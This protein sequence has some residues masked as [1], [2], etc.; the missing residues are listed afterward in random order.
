MTSTVFWL[1]LYK[2]M[3]FKVRVYIHNY[4]YP[5]VVPLVGFPRWLSGKR[6]TCRCRRCGFDTWVGKILSRRKYQPVAVF[7]PGRSHWQ[8]SLTGCSPWDWKELDITAWLS[9]RML[10]GTGYC[11]Y[12]YEWGLF[13]CISKARDSRWTLIP[14]GSLVGLFSLSSL[15]VISSLLF[16]FYFSSPTIIIIVSLGVSLFLY[17]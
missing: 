5:E 3:I 6:I 9:M 14:W 10:S 15:V 13:R 1:L 12:L 17:I 8:R 4:N 2:C 11:L 16:F 7:L